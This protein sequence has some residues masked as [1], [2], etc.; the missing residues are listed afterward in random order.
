MV[1]TL[2]Y[3][4]TR[5]F[6]VNILNVF[7]INCH[8]TTGTPGHHPVFSLGTRLV[9]SKVT[10]SRERAD[11]DPGVNQVRGLNSGNT[12]ILGKDRWS[13]WHLIGSFGPSI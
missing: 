4:N 6:S 3:I 10:L 7:I 2:P 5:D 11:T 1:F 9:T 8:V 13:I 12:Y